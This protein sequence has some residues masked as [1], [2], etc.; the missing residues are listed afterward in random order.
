MIE[1]QQEKSKESTNDVYL[2]VENL[3]TRFF[4]SKGIVKALDGVSLTVKRGEI[5]GL[6]GESGCGKSVTA[7]SIM[8]LIPD[9]PGRIVSG[10]IF[11][12][13]YNILNDLPKLA[14]INVKSEVNVVVK[15]N[16]RLIKRHNTLISKIRGK[17]MAMIFQ[18]PALALNPV[19]SVGKQISENI[20]LHNRVEIANAI[21]R[22]E[23]LSDENIKEFYEGLKKSKK[24]YRSYVNQWTRQYAVPEAEDEIVN[25]IKSDADEELTLREIKE[26]ILRRKQGND[27]SLISLMRDYYREENQLYD[28]ILK[29]IEA[30]ATNNTN[31]IAQLEQQISEQKRNIKANF[32]SY[33]MQRRFRRKKF[34]TVFEDEAKRRG[35][36]LLTLVNIGEP[37]R[38][39]DAYP[40]ELSGGMQQRAMIA[41][42][43]ASNPSLLI[44]DEP[45]TALDV[46]TQ[47]QILDLIR[48]LNQVTGTSVLFITHDLAV[49][50]EMC[51]RLGV[52]YAGNLVEESEA[53]E[54]FSNPLH[55]YTTGLLSSIPRA[56][57]RS[58]G[59]IKLESIPGSVPNLI[60][61]PTGCR[62][63]PRCKFKMDICAEKKPA[64]VSVEKNHKVACF[65]YSKEVAE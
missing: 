30:E 48:D 33:L 37:T 51:Q 41:M 32:S 60:T 29:L 14:R 43:I 5:F 20:L 38:V 7:T 16:K 61:P 63:H 65:L 31:L 19:L 50:A 26:V 45:T 62:F 4:T 40:H 58:K 6:V 42:A 49:I 47:A 9:P 46:T 10:S 55:P 15:R 59:D 56:D 53:S 11:I 21:I 2:R 54:I 28:L 25:I 44:A 1:G 12:D 57:V 36:E 35:I 23:S 3:V 39:Y 52:M 34:E 18:E 64:L 27:L 13:N 22:R 24:D 17:K 8:D